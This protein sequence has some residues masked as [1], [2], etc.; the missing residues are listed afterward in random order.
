VTPEAERSLEKANE[1]LSTA[2]AELEINL[3][4]EA[5][6]NAYLAAFH[7]ARA[8]IFER[9]GRVVK[10]HESV[11]REFTRLARDEP[12]IDKS[13][14]VFLSQAYNLKAVADTKRVRVLLCYRNAPPPLSK[15]PDASSTVST[16]CLR[17]KFSKSPVPLT[18]TRNNIAPNC[19][20]KACDIPVLYR[21]IQ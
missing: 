6:R 18:T 17:R 9:T 4:S 10:R 14:P 21:T 15:L 19:A 16:T 8:F 12:K 20:D 11:Q 13:F 2:R 5:G 7:A 1:C 3:S